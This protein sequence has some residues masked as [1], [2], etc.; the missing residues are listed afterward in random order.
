MRL[1]SKW[2]KDLLFDSIKLDLN[3]PTIKKVVNKNE[4]VNDPN[5]PL[6]GVEIKFN[7]QLVYLK[8]STYMYVSMTLFGFGFTFVKQS[9]Y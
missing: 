3:F 4:W 2:N 5:D 7:T 9:G 1:Y 6:T 8:D